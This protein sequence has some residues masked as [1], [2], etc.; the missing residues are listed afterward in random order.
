MRP[1]P[2]A[3][4][5]PRPA[6]GGDAGE[7]ASPGQAAPPGPGVSLRAALLGLLLM[8]INIYWIT[9]VE[10]RWYTLDGTCLPLFIQPVF[11]LFCL[12]LINF[13]LRRWRPRRTLRSGEL[14]TIYTLLALSCVFASHDLLQNLF[15]VIAHPF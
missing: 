12:C 9:V 2:T 3:V 4:A 15:G 13:G 10:V 11:F 14:L 7:A 8:P 1:D 5:P 6:P